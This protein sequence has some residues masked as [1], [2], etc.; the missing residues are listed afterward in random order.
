M[1]LATGYLTPLGAANI[2]ATMLIAIHR[3]HLKNG[4]WASNGGFEYNLILIAAALAVVEDGPGPLSIDA[5]KG[6][7]RKGT[8]WALASLA[9]GGLGAAAVHAASSAAA[10]PQS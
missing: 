5:I 4:P 1:L 2:V 6:H 3:V 10:P 8:G 9:A 7:E